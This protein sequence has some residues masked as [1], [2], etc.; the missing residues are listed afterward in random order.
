MTKGIWEG[1]PY[2]RCRHGG[3]INYE[4]RVIVERAIGHPLPPKAE[5]HHVNGDPADNRPGNLVVIQDHWEHKQLHRRLAVLRAGGDPFAHQWCR[6]CGQVKPFTEFY[7]RSDQRL[8]RRSSCKQCW[9][10]A[11]GR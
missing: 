10:T 1:N 3:R 5:V 6:R 7:P 9:R 4:H 2:V 8:G 11:N